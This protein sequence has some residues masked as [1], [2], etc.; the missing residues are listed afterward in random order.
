V[1]YE[2]FINLGKIKFYLENIKYFK[3]NN[4]IYSYSSVYKYNESGQLLQDDKKIDNNLII[5]KSYMNRNKLV[6]DTLILNKSGFVI[7]YV[8]YWFGQRNVNTYEYNSS[9]QLIKESQVSIDGCNA[10]STFNIRQEHL[11]Q[12]QNR[13][14]STITASPHYA[15]QSRVVYYEINKDRLNTKTGYNLVKIA[16]QCAGN[17]RN[18]ATPY[19]ELFGKLNKNLIRKADIVNEKNQRSILH[20]LYKFDE[21]GRVK[22]MLIISNSEDNPY[23]SSD[24]TYGLDLIEYD[25]Y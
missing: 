17:F 4:G 7:A 6:S 2:S 24:L 16:S 23:G 22:N 19:G 8:S 3:K 12:E 10:L 14:K 1:T 21:N 18:I 25:Y 9:G 5:S 15:S 11:I 13:I 20:Y